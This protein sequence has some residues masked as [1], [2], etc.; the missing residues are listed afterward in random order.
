[1]SNA[2]NALLWTIGYFA[3]SFVAIYVIFIADRIRSNMLGKP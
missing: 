3:L 2:A 1:M